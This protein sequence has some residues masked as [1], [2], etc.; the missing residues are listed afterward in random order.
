MTPPAHDASTGTVSLP[1]LLARL[2]AAHG[3]TPGALIATD[4][5]GTLWEGDVGVDFF[6]ALIDKGAVREAARAARAAEAREAGLPGEGDAVAL[7]RA[8][9]AA[10]LAG[11][12]PNER[13]FAMMAW[14]C[15]GFRRDELRAFAA[16]V[17]EARGLEARVRPAMRGVLA[18]ARERG[19]PVYVVSASPLEVVLAAVDRAR[20]G[21]EGVAAMTPE[22]GA[23]GVI[24]PRLAGPV[25]YGEGKLTALDRARPG[26]RAALLAAF[27]D[28]AYDAHLL[29]AARVPVAV[30]PA[31]G[32]AALAPTIAGMVTLET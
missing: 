15:A 19:V 14:A 17:L 11:A 10:H 1:A 8:L 2:D 7:A 24:L 21:V 32:L 28:S 4:A 27:G 12:Y 3:A 16:R 31:P 22:V 6:E 18:W 25:V 29:R 26:A 30:T 20:L 23:D 5:D 13:A 9:Y